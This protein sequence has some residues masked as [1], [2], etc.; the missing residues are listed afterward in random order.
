MFVEYA[1]VLPTRNYWSHRSDWFY[2]P[3]LREFIYLNTDSLNN[4]LSSLGKGIPAEITRAETGETR[5]GAEAG[6]SLSGLRAGLQYGKMDKEE[7]E[8]RLDISA[9]FRFQDLLDEVNQQEIALLENPDPRRVGRGDLIRVDGEAHPMALLKLEMAIDAFSV[10]SDEDFN[11]ALNTVGESSMIS[12][13]EREQMEAVAKVLNKLSNGEHA[14][15]L[16]SDEHTYCTQL[17]GSMMRESVYDA[18]AER[19]K[20]VLVGRVK[21]H[22][23]GNEAWNPVN[24]LDV[25][26]RY[27]PGENPGGEFVDGISEM[28]EDIDISIEDK[29][30]E[31]RGHTALVEPIAIYW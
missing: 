12:P 19:D 6:G 10:F 13:S 23:P 17:R 25:L 14:I 11:S 31:V 2:M 24:A 29:D 1:E 4:N 7:I 8:T 26:N 30:V 21:R 20:Y 9:P 15:R 28:S 18:F 3:H 16:E 22:I 27:I 5:K